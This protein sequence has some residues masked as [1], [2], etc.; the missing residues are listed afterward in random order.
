M[1]KESEVISAQV[2]LRTTKPTGPIT[3]AGLESL[4][5]PDETVQR[6][7]EFFRRAGFQVGAYVGIS[8]S[9]TAPVTTMEKVFRTSIV[10]RNSNELPLRVLPKDVADE[11]MAVTFTPPPA[12]GPGGDGP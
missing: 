5:P 12:F 10:D 9:I 6:V 1:P 8:F 11:I 7:R 2:V 3:A 4:Q